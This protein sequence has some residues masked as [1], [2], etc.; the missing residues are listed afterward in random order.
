MSETLH[1]TPNP[2]G[3]TAFLQS[4]EYEVLYGGSAGPGKSWALVIDALGAAYEWTPLGMPAYKVPSYRAALFRTEMGDLTKLID[5]AKKYYPSFGGNYTGRRVGEPGPCFEFPSGAKVF[6]CQIKDALD[7]ESHTGQEYQYVGFDELTQFLL[8]HYLYIFSRTRSTIRGLFPKVRGTTN[9]VGRGLVWVRRRFIDGVEPGGVNYFLPADDPEDNPQGV[10]VE[11]G[12][13]Y[14]LS[15]QF[16]PGFLEDNKYLMENDPAYASR[17]MQMGKT[18][19]KALLKGDWNAFGGDFFDTFDRSSEIIPPFHIDPAWELSL[20]IDPGYSSPCAA[21]LGAT[22]FEGNDYQI[23]T[24]YEKN[25]NPYQNAEGILSFVKNCQWTDGRMPWIVPCGLDAWAQKDRYSIMANEK[26]FADVFQ[27][28]GLFLD[29]AVTDRVQGWWTLK[30]LMPG[31][32]FMFEGMNEALLNELTS[33]IAD[34]KNIED[35]RGRGN[36]A[37]VPDHALDALRYRIMSTFK[38]V[39]IEKPTFQ[40]WEKDWADGLK[41]NRIWKPGRG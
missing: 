6:F 1:I 7:L 25:R 8:A 31:R 20:G 28:V 12:T 40:L 15:R 19:T 27:E 17:I 24:Y 33:A 22:D 30:S 38:S 39:K 37:S 9:P 14:A 4:S 29:R 10:K 21:V 34:N 41:K 5:E 11:P 36:D 23:A 26:T 18:Y 13:K 2:G 35:I 3:Q 32:F 16:I